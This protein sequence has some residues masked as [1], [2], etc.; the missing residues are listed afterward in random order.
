M[1][2]VVAEDVL[3]TREGLVRLLAEAGVTVVADVGD[4]DALL[5]EVDRL[6]PDVAIVDIRLPPTHT[7]EGLLAVA[8]IRRSYPEVGALILSQY[9][10]PAYA[11]RLLQDQPER[12]GYLLKERV[13]DV[14]TLTDALRRICAGET[15]IDPSIV[16]RL[17]GRTRRN[18]PLAGLTER[19]RE[20]LGAA[21]EGLSNKG[22]A[23]RLFVT[24]R[25]VEAHLTQ[26][27]SKLDIAHSEL[28]HR[29]ILA[30]LTYLRS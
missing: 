25:T 3:L 14:A 2:V 28:E 16:A 11:L 6:R 29:R 19:E 27:F 13:L 30:V 4:P 9:V 22:I 15:V 10:E 24:E 17:M 26:I 7:D 8:R 12:L 1:R 18:S 23:T 5:R 20:V 21:A